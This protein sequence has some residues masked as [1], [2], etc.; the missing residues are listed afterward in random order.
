MVP[1]R[2]A[3]ARGVA[4]CLVFA[5]LLAVE[6]GRGKLVLYV[7]YSLETAAA[8]SATLLTMRVVS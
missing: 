7:N 5:G 1:S 8:N 6:R 3:K 2:N 4:Y